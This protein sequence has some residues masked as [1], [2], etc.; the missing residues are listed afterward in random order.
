MIDLVLAGL[1][2]S[3]WVTRDVT[4]WLH[5]AYIC[6]PVRAYLRPGAL[7]TASRAA[8]ISLVAGLMLVR[9]H[10]SGVLDADELIEI[11]LLAL[12]AFCFAGFSAKRL[13]EEAAIA[14][15]RAQLAG[16]LDQIPLATIAFDAEARVVTW[17]ATAERL[18]GWSS[19]EVVGKP[20][21]IVPVGERAASDELFHRLVN[22]APLHAVEVS[23]LARDGTQLE[24]ALFSTPL[25]LDSG[26]LV[27]YADISER[28]RAQSERDEAQRR[29]QG[30]VESLPLVTYID[31]VDDH[32]TNIY[33]SPQIRELL[34][35]PA[36][37]WVAD[38][39]LFEE[40][41]HPDD[42]SRVMGQ[43]KTA[44]ETYDP[45]ESEY[46]MRHRDGHYVWVRDHSSIV[47]EREGGE[48]FARG[49]LLDITERKR[50]ESQVLQGQ[51]MEALGQFAGGIAHDFNN[52]LTGIGGYAEL[53][54]SRAAGDP[55]L[56][57][58]LDGIKAASAEAASLTARLLT[59][60]RRHVLE[61]TL[62]DPNVIVREAADFLE[63]LVRADIRLDVRLG[64]DV[65]WVEA[66]PAQLKQVVLNLALNARDAMPEGG[67]MTLQTAGNGD[68]ATIL[69]RDTGTGMDEA[70][71]ARAVEPFF[72]TKP[73]GEGTGL[74]LAVAYGVVDGL[75]GSLLLD[76][77]PG[78]GTIVEIV[79]PSVADVG[80]AAEQAEAAPAGQPPTARIL[81]T[82]DREIVRTLAREVLEN[83]GFEVAVAASGTEALGIVEESP[84]FDLLLTDVVMPGL[85]G[86]ELARAIRALR[87]TQRVLYMSG[88]T[89]DVLAESEL[90]NESTA[91]LRKP[92]QNAELIE[93]VVALLAQPWAAAALSNAPNV[94]SAPAG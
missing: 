69:V 77:N 32:A 94:S 60:S 83:A 11:P 42:R 47:T 28:L 45:F 68:S 7:A 43:V 88:Y 16:A 12:L 10:G 90:E 3:L 51:K 41:L 72:T 80:G 70:T 56:T 92:F 37:D 73:E 24:L 35:W 36:E 38:P 50:L 44:N 74:G 39:R 48:A 18:F 40:L 54:S 15:E 62:V 57:R 46:R 33:T 8:V 19:E 61:R 84:P 22:G 55:A 13:R 14:A 82:E 66:D 30:L 27:L 1:L 93:S 53:A 25:R 67:T 87:P 6:V 78:E 91:F 52:L 64:A 89:D 59:F 85:S 17:N 65:P 81:V 75:G 71:L 26:A 4:L 2:I 34:G 58:C 86:L 31:R 21:P 79:L 49:F 20:N 23:R 76:S 63:R 29:Y 9:L 5:L